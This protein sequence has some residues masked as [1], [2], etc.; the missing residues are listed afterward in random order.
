MRIVTDIS[1]YNYH[2]IVSF[3]NES[4]EVIPL[5]GGEDKRN[6]YRERV[7]NY[8]HHISHTKGLNEMAVIRHH[9]F[10]VKE[11]IA[12]SYPL[13]LS[14]EIVEEESQVLGKEVTQVS[15]DYKYDN[16]YLMSNDS[17]IIEWRVS[18]PIVP[19][20]V[21][22]IV[23]EA[24]ER[25]SD[26]VLSNMVTIENDILL[27]IRG[28]GIN[29]IINRRNDQRLAVEVRSPDPQDVNAFNLRKVIIIADAFDG[30]LLFD[31]R[32]QKIIGQFRLP[33]NDFPQQIEPFWGEILI[34]GKYGVYLLD[35]NYMKLQVLWNEGRVGVLTKYYKYIFFSSKE[36]LYLLRPGWIRYIRSISLDR[37]NN[38]QAIELL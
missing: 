15:I 21:K 20:K 22:E 24:I 31:E 11:S 12:K 13:L 6:L 33:E 34:K 3:L 10:G 36:K 18:D 4:V 26:P 38:L 19:K 5:I 16:L 14:N 17:G 35:P 37:L 9:L 25:L 30:I 7:G 29:K 32:Q 27:S 1:V 23:P 28:Y 8:R 2:L